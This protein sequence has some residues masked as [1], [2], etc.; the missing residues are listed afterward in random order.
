MIERGKRGLSPVRGVLGAVPVIALALALAGCGGGSSGSVPSGQAA[1]GGP[2]TQN[3]VATA[4]ES[5][6]GSTTTLLQGNTLQIQLPANT[7]SGYTWKLVRDGSPHMAVVSL[8]TSATASTRG[9]TSY[10]TTVEKAVTGGKTQVELAYMSPSGD[11]SKT[12]TINVNVVQLHLGSGD[13]RLPPAK[14]YTTTT[15]TP[16]H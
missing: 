4:T 14:K 9:K 1:N 5:D 8:P 10:Q 2:Q 3:G 12:W 11:Q 13:F 15:T 6:S 7:S 16:K